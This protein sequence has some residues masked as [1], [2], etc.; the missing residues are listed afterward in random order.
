M[1]AISQRMTTRRAMTK[2][3][4]MKTMSWKRQSRNTTYPLIASS[5]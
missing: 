4:K 1:T 2:R 5:N 3:R